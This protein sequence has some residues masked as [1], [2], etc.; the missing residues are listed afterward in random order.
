MIVSAAPPSNTPHHASG[1]ATLNLSIWC[2]KWTSDRNVCCICNT[3]CLAG[4]PAA[5]PHAMD[6]EGGSS[7]E[8]E[9]EDEDEDED[10][11]EGSCAVG[12]CRML[13]L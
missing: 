5:G 1:Q 7:E 12:R 4:S 8:E 10:E 13:Q 2:Y 9:G 11:G 3:S 6:V